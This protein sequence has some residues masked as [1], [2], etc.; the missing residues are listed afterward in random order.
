MSDTTGLV[1]IDLTPASWFVALTVAYYAALFVLAHRR[2]A[3]PAGG[4]TPLMV[5][6]VPAH[7]EESVLAATLASLTALH[8]GGEHRVLVVDD[9][10]TDATGTIADAWAA[11]DPRVRVTHRRPPD[12]GLGKSEALNHGFGLVSRWAAAGDPWLGDHALEDVVLVI[13][14][15]DGRLDPEALTT[16]A[17]YFADPRVASV[18]I[19]VRIANAR[20]NALARMQDIEF[21]GFSWLVQ[22]ARDRLGSS[23]LGGNGQFTRASALASLGVAPWRPGALTEDLDLG[24][25]LVAAGWRT[26]FCWAAHVEQQGL[27]SWRPL[28]RQRTRWIQGHYQ[29]WRHLGALVGARRVAWTARADLALYLLLVVTVLV[30]SATVVV[31]LLGALGVVG[32]TN[33]LLLAVPYGRPRRLASLVLSVLPVVVFLRTYQRHSAH[34]FRWWQ[35]PAAAVAFTGYGYMWFWVSL[36]ALGNIALRRNRW[37]KTPRVGAA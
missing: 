10:S 6:V 3:P 7:Q 18:Q 25:R 16:V 22:I 9:G 37:V 23:G 12:A 20:D 15:A 33:D 2:P 27:T 13:V 31:G 8:Y 29:C 21:V 11:R 24:L 19:G 28:L 1:T 35:V 14:D 36:R 17:P 34:P 5:L 4:A 32:V 26:R 30:V